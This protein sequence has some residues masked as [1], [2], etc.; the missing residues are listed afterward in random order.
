MVVFPYLY[1]QSFILKDFF[2]FLKKNVWDTLARKA[3]KGHNVALTSRL[4]PTKRANV[5]GEEEVLGCGEGR[6]T[7]TSKALVLLV[8]SCP[9]G[10]LCKMM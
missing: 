6:G 5:Y 10:T 1:T 9:S 2:F 7:V 8:A 4:H 3:K